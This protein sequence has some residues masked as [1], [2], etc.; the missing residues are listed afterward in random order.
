MF[1]DADQP[2]ATYRSTLNQDLEKLT[3]A[4]SVKVTRCRFRGYAV[5]TPWTPKPQAATIS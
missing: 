5:P 3:G 1:T 4:S 2:E